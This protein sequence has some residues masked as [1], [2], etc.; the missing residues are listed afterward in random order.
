VPTL[1]AARRGLNVPGSGAD[2]ACR[3]VQIAVPPV[4]AA[5]HTARG[6]LRQRL[7]AQDIRA[8]HIA[9]LE[10][11]AS[12]LLGAALEAGNAEPLT[13]SVKLFTLISSVRVRC[14]RGGELRDEPYGIRERVLEG[15]AFAWGK[16]EYVDR[17]VDLWA[18]VAKPK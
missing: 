6:T 1:R 2:Q 14:P 10:L 17:S 11:V 5:L 16:R 18:E 15:V 7:G 8:D 13:L 9:A 4:A 3:T 12:E